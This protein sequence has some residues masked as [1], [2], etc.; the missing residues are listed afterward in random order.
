MIYDH[1]QQA[2]AYRGV[3]AALGDVLGAL[4]P[5]DLLAQPTGR[6]VLIPDVA[7]LI[8]DRYTPAPDRPI[9]WETHRRFADLQLMLD[10]EE[11]LG[12]LPLMAAP[13]I[14]TPYDELRDVCF[15]HPPADD[16]PTAPRHLPLTPGHFAIFLPSDLH[17]PGLC[18]LDGNAQPVTKA[19]IKIRV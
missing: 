17:A 8:I 11:R 12:W 4:D 13:P 15:Y 14:K 16:H 10:G 1:F 7:D 2:R 19:V 3:L 9:V 6:R 5:I 18:P